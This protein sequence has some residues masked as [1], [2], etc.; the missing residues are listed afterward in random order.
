MN[1]NTHINKILPTF[2]YGLI[3][4][5]VLSRLFPHPFNFTSVGGL[6]L[7]V[8]A[9]MPLRI[10]WIAPIFTLLITDSISGFYEPLVMLFVYLGFACCTLVGHYILYVR[11]NI[12][13]ITSSSFVS[14]L[15]FFIISNFGFWLSG[16]YYPL[17]LDGLVDCY[18]RAIPYFKYTL[19]GDVLYTFFLFGCY[20]F[21]LISLRLNQQKI[22]KF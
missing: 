19:A 3:I 22:D 13:R 2:I 10:A 4:F 8:G 12:L 7:F 1:S 18:I 20:E 16:N 15:V 14:A 21:I 6:A 17:T 9:F 5:T 11:R